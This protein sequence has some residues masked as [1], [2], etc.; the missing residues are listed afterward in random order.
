MRR[1]H[2]RRAAGVFPA[3][4]GPKTTAYLSASFSFAFRASYSLMY[5][6]GLSAKASRQPLQQT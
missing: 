3:G 4:N 6:S 1:F 2:A 5:F